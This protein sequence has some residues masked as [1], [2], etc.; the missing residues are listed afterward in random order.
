MR[1]SG[2]GGSNAGDKCSICREQFSKD[3]LVEREIGD[4]KL[5]YFCGD[6]IQGLSSDAEKLHTH[7]HQ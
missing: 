1:R 2:E 5:L 4:Y 3:M 6:C 7:D